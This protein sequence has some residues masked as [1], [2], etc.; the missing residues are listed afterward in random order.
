M[1]STED[2]TYDLQYYWEVGIHNRDEYSSY[3]IYDSSWSTKELAMVRIHTLMDEF[4][5]KY[6]HY[7]GLYWRTQINNTGGNFITEIRPYHD[8]IT[9]DI[10]EI[11]LII[12]KRFIQK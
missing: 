2:P 10:D 12:K 7:N 3:Y 11:C 8:E 5:N 4:E 1:T 9:A 6:R